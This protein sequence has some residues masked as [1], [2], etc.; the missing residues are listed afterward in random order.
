MIFQPHRYT[1]TRDCFEEFCTAFHE[2]DLLVLTEIY[3]AGE[4]KIAGVEAAALAQ[5]IE[6][7]GH[8]AV[9]FV[10]DLERV[11]PAL[12]PELRP[13][14]LVLTLGAGSIAGLGPRLLE[15]LRRSTP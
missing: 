4:E 1:R 2:A 8:R 15:A 11:V 13:G 6:T 7:R 12:L 9:R 14:D 10:A 5:A 3:S